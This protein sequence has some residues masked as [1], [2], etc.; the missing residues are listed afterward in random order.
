MLVPVD[1]RPLVAHVVATALAVPGS[2]VIVVVGHQAS[3][4]RAALRSAF[5]GAALRFSTQREQRGTGDAVASG[6]RA[7]SGGAGSVLV[8]SGDVPLITRATL[9]RLRAARER[10]GAD[11]A[12]L[13]MELTD[14]AHYGRVVR[15]GRRVVRVVEYLDADETTRSVREVNAGVYCFE[16]GFLRRELKRLRTDNAKGEVYLTDLV[17]AAASGQGALGIR[18]SP[19]EVRGVNTWAE[20]ATLEALVRARVAARLMAGGVRVTDPTRLIVHSS[21][22]V[23]SGCC[24]GPDVTLTGRTNIGPNTRIDQGAVLRHCEIGPRA[25]IRAYCVLEGIAVPADSDVGPY[26][27][28]SAE[29]HDPLPEPIH[30]VRPASGRAPRRTASRR[31]SRAGTRKD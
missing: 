20:Q 23:G 5:P 7:V 18:V 10:R 12:L 11:L 6:L 21:V 16:L 4:V 30:P 25:R 22:R 28:L 27:H 8:L 1:G 9:T 24:L 26:V 15:E 3:D 17:A 13:S 2:T 29:E 19:D 31:P 14:P